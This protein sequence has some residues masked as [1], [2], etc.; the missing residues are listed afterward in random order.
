MQ[1]SDPGETHTPTTRRAPQRV[2]ERTQ[3]LRAA[4]SQRLFSAFIAIACLAVLS[5][6][7]WI[8][9]SADGHGTHTQLGLK[10]C[11]WAVTLDAP[12]MT[13][14]MTT[15][16]AH[17]GEGHWITSFLTQ[18]MGSLLVLITTVVFWGALVQTVSGA[19][20]G[21]MIQPALRPRVFI[22]LGVLL[23]AAWG[24]K[25]ITW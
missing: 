10:P 23:L 24:Y 8:N 9:P 21:T 22:M 12:C 1:M 16:F 13:C 11:I 17:A 6:G 3:P 15:S 18:P 20:I 25:V 5:M 7:A 4:L 19:R 2:S 14:G